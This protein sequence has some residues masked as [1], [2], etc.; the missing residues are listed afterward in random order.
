M[1]SFWFGFVGL[2]GL[3]AVAFREFELLGL[4]LVVCWVAAFEVGCSMGFIS[5][6]VVVLIVWVWCRLGV[7][8]CWLIGLLYDGLGWFPVVVVWV[9]II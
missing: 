2:L 3:F 4:M 7:V 1:R 9:V 8:V 5:G 6:F